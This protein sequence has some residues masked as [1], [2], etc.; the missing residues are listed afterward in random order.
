MMQTRTVT[1]DVYREQLVYGTRIIGFVVLTALAAQV[2]IPTTPVP[3]TLQT[4]CVLL[5]GGILDKKSAFISMLSYVGLGIIGF[6]VFA[7]GTSGI[8]KIL[9]PTGGYLLSFPIAAAVVAILIEKHKRYLWIL[10]SMSVGTLLIFVLGT[11]HLYNVLFRNWV[12]ALSSGFL[13]FTIWDAVKVLAATSI[14][15]RY[16]KAYRD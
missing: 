10:F 2:E 8:M 13:V 12:Q 7:G 15:S 16:Y 11:I 3:F 1:V 14:V 6:P 9:G 5:A 4:L